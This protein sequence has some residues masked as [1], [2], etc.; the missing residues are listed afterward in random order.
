[1][2]GDGQEER[3]F[4]WAWRDSSEGMHIWND[5]E[6]PSVL[7]GTDLTMQKDD[8]HYGGWEHRGEHNINGMLYDWH[9]LLKRAKKNSGKKYA[10]VHLMRWSL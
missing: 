4:D 3:A 7:S 10:K 2:A 5:M 8:I 6:E 1:M 9:R